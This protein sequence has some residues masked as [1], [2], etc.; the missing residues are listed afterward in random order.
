MKKFAFAIVLAAA[1]FALQAQHSES[2]YLYTTKSF[3]GSS[4]KNIKATTSHGNIAI[5]DVPAS[6][7][8][9]EVYIRASSSDRELSKEDIQKKLDEYYTLEISLSGDVLTASAQQKKEIPF[10]QSG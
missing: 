6:Q 9:V 3:Q 4:P 2:D 7:C 1:C 8:R 10:S 5:S